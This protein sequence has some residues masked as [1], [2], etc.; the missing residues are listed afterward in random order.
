MHGIPKSQVPESSSFAWFWPGRQINPQST[1]STSQSKAAVLAMATASVENE[2]HSPKFNQSHSPSQSQS[3]RP[4]HGHNPSPS[5]NQSHSLKLS[6]N[7]KHFKLGQVR[8]TFHIGQRATS[9]AGHG[10]SHSPSHSHV[11]ITTIIKSNFENQQPL[12]IG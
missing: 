8:N 1:K 11:I 12:C 6:V 2:S 9:N 4:G 3:Q 10:H 5:H 7:Q